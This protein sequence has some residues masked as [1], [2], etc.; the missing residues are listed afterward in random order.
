MVPNRRE[1][2]GD[3]YRPSKFHHEGFYGQETLR[4]P[5]YPRYWISRPS[6]NV[7][8]KPKTLQDVISVDKLV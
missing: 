3:R 1:K 7:Y 2:V 4:K 6:L 5:F 8:M